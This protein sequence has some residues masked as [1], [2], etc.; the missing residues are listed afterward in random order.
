M[1]EYFFVIFMCDQFN[2]KINSFV[3]QVPSYGK[4]DL[5]IFYI[6]QNLAPFFQR[7]IAYFES[8]SSNQIEV[9]QK[10]FVM[11]G[12]NVVCKTIC[13]YYGRVLKRLHIEF[14]II[15][16]NEK[17]V[18]HFAMIVHG[19]NGWYYMDPLKDLLANQMGFF[20]RFF[21]VLLN[22][23]L[24]PIKYPGLI[25]LNKDYIQELAIQTNNFSYGHFTDFF[26]DLLHD[27]FFQKPIQS[28]FNCATDEFSM[29]LVKLKFLSQYLIN[30]NS[31]PGLY[32]RWQYYSYL[33][34]RVFNRPECEK[35]KIEIKDFDFIQI[36]VIDSNNSSAIFQESVDEDNQYFLKR[37]R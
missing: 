12:A 6:Y 4:K 35:V 22:Y 16:T 11:K 37:V 28:F 36:S 15:P 13:Q 23:G 10:G 20:P 26:L 2:Q 17:K 14:K 7:D 29:I 34:S 5:T 31:I 25:E 21:G 8:D 1:L 3:K 27:E 32:E 19:D 9:Y 33:K 18:P 30:I 24:V